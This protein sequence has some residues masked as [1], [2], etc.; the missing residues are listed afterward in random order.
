[1]TIAEMRAAIAL[2]RAAG[3]TKVPIP[4]KVLTKLFDQIARQPKRP[5]AETE[6]APR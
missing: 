5:K 3:A 2:S 1:M 6:E 4:R